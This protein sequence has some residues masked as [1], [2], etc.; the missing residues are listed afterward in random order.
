MGC[1]QLTSRVGHTTQSGL[2]TI[3][4]ASGTQNML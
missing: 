1:S 3:G 4:A 2:I